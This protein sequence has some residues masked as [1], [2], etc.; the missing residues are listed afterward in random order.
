MLPPAFALATVYA[1]AL[2]ARASL[3]LESRKLLAL[4]AA[5]E[6]RSLRVAG[7]LSEVA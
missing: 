5:E 7:G 3:P 6:T 4:L 2:G 1:A